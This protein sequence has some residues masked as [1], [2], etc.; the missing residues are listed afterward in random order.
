MH[1]KQH[2]YILAIVFVGASVLSIS[3]AQT[4]S[5]SASAVPSVVVILELDRDRY[6]LAQPINVT[7]LLQNRGAATILIPKD[8]E[9]VASPYGGIEI[10]F[11]DSTNA[12]VSLPT[13]SAAVLPNMIIPPAKRP[14]DFVALHPGYTY[15]R[16]VTLSIVPKNR[17]RYKLIARFYGPSITQAERTAT[18]EALA[19]VVRGTYESAPRFVSI[20]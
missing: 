7:C 10:E 16:A 4:I 13:A 18:V 19:G 6:D 14:Q 15:G 3:A 17:G 2:L 9:L 12:V 1:D 5:S 20:E 8:V 11:F